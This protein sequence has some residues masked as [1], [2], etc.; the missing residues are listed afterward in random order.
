MPDWLAAAG[1]QTPNGWALVQFK[2]LLAGTMG[3]GRLALL[4]LALALAI[5]VGLGLVR[6][7]VRQAF[8][9]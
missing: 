7:R 2:A 8:L 3:P 1:R 9:T 4:C 6:R 5:A